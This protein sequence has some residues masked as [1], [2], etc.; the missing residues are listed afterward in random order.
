MARRKPIYDNDQAQAFRRIVRPAMVGLIG[1]GEA[2][3]TMRMAD[4]FSDW[5]YELIN[6]VMATTPL[7]DE[8]MEIRRQLLTGI[9]LTGRTSMRTLRGR[10]D[11][12]PWIFPH[13]YGGVLKPTNAKMLTVPIYHALRAD[14]SPKYRTASAWKRWGSFI[15]TPK[16]S[17][18]SYIAYKDANRKLRILYVLVDQVEIP[19]RLGLNRM[20]DRM[21]GQLTAEWARIFIFYGGALGMRNPWVEAA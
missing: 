7:N 3:L 5:L 13:E 15:Y 8:G 11:V 21:L 2:L 16:G 10:I 14:G 12:Y 6:N 20:A 18:R 9:R 1:R 4:A 17:E 19:A